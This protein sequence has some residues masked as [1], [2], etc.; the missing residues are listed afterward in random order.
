MHALRST[1]EVAEDSDDDDGNDG[2]TTLVRV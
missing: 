2:H 1:G